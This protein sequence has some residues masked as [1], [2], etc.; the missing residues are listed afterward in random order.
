[1]KHIEIPDLEFEQ[2]FF[3]VFIA[4]YHSDMTIQ[5]N[6]MIYKD[7]TLIFITN[8]TGRYATFGDMPIKL[9]TIKEFYVELDGMDQIPVTG[10]EI[11][12][13]EGIITIKI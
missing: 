10:F 3:N 13:K 7:D 2:K 6:A 12:G 9:S 5:L 1:M 11:D 4:S 8:K